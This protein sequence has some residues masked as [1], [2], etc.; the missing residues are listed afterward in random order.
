[1]KRRDFLTISIKSAMAA[2]MT[3]AIPF[4][5]L[6]SHTAHAAIAAAGLSDPAVQPLFTNLAPNA[7]SASFKFVPKNNKL[8][9]QMAQAVQ[10]TGLVGTD[11]VTPVSTTV[12][13]YGENGKGVTW[14]GAA[15]G[16]QSALGLLTARREFG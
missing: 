6:R 12:W 14:P 9:I 10:M 5:L 15:G 8:G 11:G 3:S 7:M 16:Y 13:G 4:S 1:M 2:G